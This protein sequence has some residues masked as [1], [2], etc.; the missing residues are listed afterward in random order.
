M[1]TTIDAA[2]L[3]TTAALL[4]T[5]RRD[6]ESESDWATRA[7]SVIPHLINVAAEHAPDDQAAPQPMTDLAAVTTLLLATTAPDPGETRDAA[8]ARTAARAG[9][10]VRVAADATQPT[11]AD[12]KRE[13]HRSYVTHVL[14]VEPITRESRATPGLTITKAKVRLASNSDLYD[15][16]DPQT[17]IVKWTFPDGNKRVDA[18]TADL[19][20]RCQDAIGHDVR[21][22]ACYEPGTGADGKPKRNKVLL[23]IVDLGVHTPRRDTP[24]A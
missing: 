16:D 13:G 10:L 7:L 20:R 23:D 24:G 9:H 11:D 21:V 18:A 17:P 22:Y 12:V 6:D 2:T 1:T 4:H 8:L 15:S 14:G 3:L 5:P 19:A